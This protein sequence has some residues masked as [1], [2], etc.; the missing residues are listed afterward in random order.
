MAD[1]ERLL[2]E[3]ALDAL[4]RLFDGHCRAVDVWALLVATGVALRDTP[5]RPVVE[6]PVAGLRAVLR[7]GAAWDEQRDRALVATDPLR[8]YLS[9]V[10]PW[11]PLPLPGWADAEPGVADVTMNV[12]SRRGNDER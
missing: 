9:R 12:K 4:D 1:G 6:E 2:L 7:S 11:P 5:H 3:N 8:Q 10:L